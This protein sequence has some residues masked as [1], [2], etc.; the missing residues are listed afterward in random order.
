MNIVR[1][2]LCLVINHGYLHDGWSGQGLS[3]DLDIK[4]SLVG[5]RLLL[6]CDWAHGLTNYV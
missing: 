3:N 5:W 1:E 4:L 2:S 6:V